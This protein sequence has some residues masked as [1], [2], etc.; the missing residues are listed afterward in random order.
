M[1]LHSLLEHTDVAVM[2]DNEA[3]Y[4]ICRRNLGI[5]RAT[6]ASLNRWLAQAISPVTASLRFDGAPSMEST[7]FQTIVVPYPRT[8]FR[9]SSYAPTVSAERPRREIH[10]ERRSGDHAACVSS[11]ADR[12][13]G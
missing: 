11:Q 7:E 3:L 10:G 5:E 6:F 9:L 2:Y 12:G 13:R 8:H 4:D 1:F